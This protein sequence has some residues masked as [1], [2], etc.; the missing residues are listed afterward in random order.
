MKIC[1]RCKKEFDGKRCNYCQ[2]EY[3]NTHK[4]E[5]AEYYKAWYI[6]NKEKLKE[7]RIKHKEELIAYQKEYRE[8]NRKEMIAKSKIY[9]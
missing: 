9:Y 7:H 6:K 2:R 1:R 4:V 8:E 3:Y 5:S